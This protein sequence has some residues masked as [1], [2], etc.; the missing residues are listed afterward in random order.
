MALCDV[1]L[2][3]R[4]CAFYAVEERAKQNRLLTLQSHRF[5]LR[6]LSVGNFCC[7]LWR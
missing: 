3:L 4:L 1:V 5:I 7:T 2:W 6:L